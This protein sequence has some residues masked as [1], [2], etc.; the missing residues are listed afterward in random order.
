MK[1]W[2][3]LIS[4][5]LIFTL[6]LAGC[7]GK[8][9]DEASGS[10]SNGKEVVAWAWNINVPVLEK[11]AEEYQKENPDFKLKVVDMG[12]EDVY[13]KLTTGLQAGGKVPS[14]YRVS[15]R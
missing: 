1:R 12:R 14:R 9:A 5:T 4:F 13:S 10:G 2:F 15:G 11:A 6:I 7:G 3:G 8:S